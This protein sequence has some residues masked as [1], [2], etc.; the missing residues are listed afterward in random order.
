M[1]NLNFE[2][3]RLQLS[4]FIPEDSEE[5]QLLNSDAFVR[6]YLWDD[7]IIDAMTADE[8]ME[9][10]IR[11][12]EDDQFGLWK[13]HL[14]DQ[15]TLMGYVGLWYFLDE[16]QPQLLYA[17]LKPYTEQGYATEAGSAIIDYAFKR[18]GFKYLIAATDEPHKASQRVAKR[19]GMSFLEKRI[20]NRKPMVFFKI[21]ERSR[22][23][24]VV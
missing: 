5:F 9:Q 20:E 18:L 1:E 22:N 13:I 4:P 10:N 3:K 16:P 24:V 14:K 21:E 15:D 7:R 8:I 23:R 12:F 11:H 2:T 6:K 19:L 17:L